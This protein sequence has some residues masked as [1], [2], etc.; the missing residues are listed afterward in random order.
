MINWLSSFTN[1]AKNNFQASQP[2]NPTSELFGTDSLSAMGT[3]PTVNGIQPNLNSST[4]SPQ[5]NP[6]MVAMNPDSASYQN[7]YAK[8]QPFPKPIFMG[9]LGEKPLYG[10]ARLFIS[11]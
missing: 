9:Y 6:F 11:A 10:G 4:A 8:N 3:L 1:P 7:N 2:S 5:R